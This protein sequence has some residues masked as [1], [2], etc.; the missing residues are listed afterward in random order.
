MLEIIIPLFVILILFGVPIYVAILIPSIIGFMISFPAIDM[1]VIIQKMVNGIDVFSLLAIPFFMFAADIMSKGDIGNKLVNFANS[2][3]GHLYG[4]LAIT[5]ILTCTIFGA[6][7]GAGPAAIVAL[8]PLLYP[9]LVAKGYGEKESIGCITS[10]STLAMLVPP[11]IA[12]ILYGVT[13]NV[14]I[15]KIFMSGLTIG[16]ICAALFSAYAFIDAIRKK[17]PRGKKASLKEVLIATKNAFWALGLPILILVGI[18]TGVM[19]PTEASAIAVGYVVLVELFIYKS[20][21]FKEI[22]KIAAQSGRMVAMIFILIA[23]GSL[24]AY[25]FNAAQIPQSLISLTVGL[26]AISILISMNIILLVAGMII[27]PNS[28]IIVFTPLLYPLA[29]SIGIH[30]LHLGMM[31]VFNCSIGMITPPFGLNI[32]VAQ[33]T[34]KQPYTTITKSLY[35][36]IVLMLLLLL[37][38]M[39]VPQLSLFL[40]N[41]M[42]I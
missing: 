30:P 21:N 6:I 41:R 28:I 32:F 33:G 22:S 10:S 25:L 27:D 16:I 39:F 29:M 8:G 17:I 4:G 24:L 5:T 2:L 40:P 7:S 26:P 9:A 42:T 14:S 1:V 23:S 12:M 19:T 35:P 34:F 18:Y 36:Y 3:V 13:A 11:G 15:G 31:L 37:L 20:L 38:V